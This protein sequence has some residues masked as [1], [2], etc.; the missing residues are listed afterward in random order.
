MF[1]DDRGR[2]LQIA[3]WIDRLNEG[4]AVR[5]EL[6]DQVI[7]W[8]LGRIEQCCERLSAAYRARHPEIAALGL[9]TMDQ[10]LND[11]P[12]PVSVA[13]ALA[14][15]VIDTFAP[16][17]NALPPPP[18]LRAPHPK[19]GSRHDDIA[20]ELRKMEPRLREEGITALYMFGSAARRE[21]GP[22]SDIDLTFQVAP[23]GGGTFSRWDQ[24]RIADELAAAMGLKVDLVEWS[25]LQEEIKERVTQDLIRIFGELSSET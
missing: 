17:L 8:L 18:P 3:E 2:L 20:T 10:V 24:L 1:E 14:R 21:D 19:P 13:T 15:R 16:L 5:S 6:A 4:F 9:P 25:A 12:P 23:V 7:W 22:E 11:Q